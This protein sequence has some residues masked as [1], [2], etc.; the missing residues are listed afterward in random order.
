MQWEGWWTYEFCYGKH[1]KQF[2]LD[3]AGNI[4][5]DANFALGTH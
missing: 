1:M 5:K 4:P 2:H 3:K